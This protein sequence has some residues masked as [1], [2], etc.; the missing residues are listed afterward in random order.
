MTEHKKQAV[1]YLRLSDY[2][3]FTEDRMGAAY[4]EII[5]AILNKIGAE[6]AAEFNDKGNSNEGFKQLISYI[7]KNIPE[8]LIMIDSGVQ[9]VEPDFN[10][11]YPTV[12]DAIKFVETAVKNK[13]QQKRLFYDKR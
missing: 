6:R 5:A 4:A 13:A 10:R 7:E 2:S 11:V 9:I 12:N 8:S 3:R 1:V